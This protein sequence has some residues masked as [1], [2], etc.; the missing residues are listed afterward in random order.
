MSEID[1]LEGCVE[2]TRKNVLVGPSVRGDIGECTLSS[3]I[4]ACSSWRSIVLL[5]GV[6]FISN[7][8][9]L[10]RTNAMG[11][12]AHPEVTKDKRILM[13]II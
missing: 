4:T 1:L 2:T 10:R 8:P 7:V 3:F 6:R 13:T 5:S 11:T 12:R 9:I